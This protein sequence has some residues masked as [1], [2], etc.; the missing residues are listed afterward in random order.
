M[1]VSP[2]PI[3]R[4]RT[5]LFGNF[6]E[7][8]LNTANVITVTPASATAINTRLIAVGYQAPLL[9]V[10]AGPTSLLTPQRCIRTLYSCEATIGLAKT[11]SSISDTV[12]TN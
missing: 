8:R 7:G 6:E 5:F 9:P 12:S 2:G 11:T 10:A 1:P 3:Q 4:D